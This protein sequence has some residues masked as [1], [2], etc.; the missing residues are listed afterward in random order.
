MRGSKYPYQQRNQLFHNEGASGFVDMSDA[1]GAPFQS[2][3]VGRGAAFGDIDNDGDIDI[4]VTNNNGLVRLLLNESPARNGGVTLDL[5]GGTGHRYAVGARVCLLRRGRPQSS[6]RVRADGSYL[7]ASDLRV[8]FGLSKDPLS[9]EGIIVEWPRPASG[10]RKAE[11][12]RNIKFDTP[13]LTLREGSGEP[14]RQK[15]RSIE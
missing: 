15:E 2:K 1:A 8:H 6:R 13:T 11:I 5:K 4:V 10:G 3:A 14:W 9:V 7:G 12:W